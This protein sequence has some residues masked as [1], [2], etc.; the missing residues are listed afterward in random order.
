VPGDSVISEVS[1]VTLSDAGAAAG[2]SEGPSGA[3][4]SSSSLIAVV[5]VPASVASSSLTVD[6]P[7]GAPPPSVPSAGAPAAHTSSTHSSLV[8][9]RSAK[10]DLIPVLVAVVVARSSSLR[11]RL[12]TD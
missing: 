4:A 1:A 6:K 10:S 7:A 12:L 11:L 5:E 2:A 3:S 9:T 8:C